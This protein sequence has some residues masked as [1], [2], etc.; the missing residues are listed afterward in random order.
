M[1][2]NH[3]LL[4]LL[5]SSLLAA[6]AFASV[7]AKAQDNPL[8]R[9]AHSGRP[10]Y[11]EGDGLILAIE[12]QEAQTIEGRL[13]FGTQIFP[14]RGQ[15]AGEG[16]WDGSFQAGEQSF[17][18][19]LRATESGRVFETG[20][21]RYALQQ[22][23][24]PSRELPPV[25]TEDVDE[26][27][28]ARPTAVPRETLERAIAAYRR[29][30]LEGTRQVLV[31]LAE[32]GHV[33]ACYL[34]ARILLGNANDPGDPQG[35]ARLLTTAASVDHPGALHTLGSM[36]V[37]GHGVP[38]D[39]KRGAEMMTRA[40]ML[41]DPAAM[42]ELAGLHFEGV[43][44]P[45]NAIEAAAWVMLAAQRGDAMAIEIL[46]EM[47]DDGSFE[48]GDWQRIERRATTLAGSLPQSKQQPDYVLDFNRFAGDAHAASETFV[49][50][51]TT[52]IGTW[53]IDFEATWERSRDA[54]L[55]DTL[56]GAD[57][58]SKDPAEKERQVRDE[59]RAFLATWITTYGK[60][61]RMTR[62]VSGRRFEGQ[63]AAMGWEDRQIFLKETAGR[64]Q[65]VV[66]EF[67]T[68]DRCVW[69][70]QGERPMT[71]VMTRQ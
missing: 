1:F 35:A 51:D 70:L 54:F 34:V 61:G 8:D 22:I 66:L 6:V 32:K 64:D 2:T 53:V 4:A 59:M 63:F 19:R 68:R 5:G 37:Q 10:T 40:A 9:Q 13:V 60:D 17:A 20:T 33:G 48:R 18:F 71:L 36:T 45:E 69:M 28:P 62:E 12:R 47:R 49:V 3:R 14:F 57:E 11:F 21:S 26:E 46:A 56:R 38:A 42:T 43:G 23:E 16:R 67:Q 58:Y 24:K 7:S 41:G 65:Q 52:P 15:S 31:P 44:V 25:V 55:K 30:D 27:I 39:A 50:D 29:G